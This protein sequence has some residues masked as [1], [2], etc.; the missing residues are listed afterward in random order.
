M[1]PTP[2]TSIP[3][4]ALPPPDAQVVKYLITEEVRGRPRSV[5][6]MRLK[7]NA[8]NR[9]RAAEAGIVLHRSAGADAAAAAA[10][11]PAAAGAATDAAP[12]AELR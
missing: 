7:N 3:H 9:R 12:A 11:A 4:A 5:Y 10:A 1:P 8:A 6:G 2:H